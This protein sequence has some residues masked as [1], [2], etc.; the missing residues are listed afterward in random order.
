MRTKSKFKSPAHL[1]FCFINMTAC[2]ATYKESY[3]NQDIV[4]IFESTIGCH[5]YLNIH[6]IFKSQTRQT[7]HQ[8]CYQQSFTCCGHNLNE[9]LTCHPTAFSDF[10]S[11]TK[12]CTLS[13]LGQLHIFFSICFVPISNGVGR[14][15][16][17]GNQTAGGNRP[18]NW[19]WLR[20]S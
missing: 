8:S 16:V 20:E 9:Q 12:C 17:R 11:F 14:M 15:A 2:K 19:Q 7:F 5:P 3:H 18:H 13:Q 4:I 10:L 1:H 6:I